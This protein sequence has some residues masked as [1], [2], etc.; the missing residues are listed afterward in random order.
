MALTAYKVVV[1]E[2][3]EKH[4]F[5]IDQY[6]QAMQKW[7]EEIADLDCDT[8]LIAIHVNDEQ[9][10]EQISQ[11][12]WREGPAFSCPTN[13]SWCQKYQIPRSRFLSAS[14][15]KYAEDA[16]RRYQEWSEGRYRY[17]EED[18]NGNGCT[19]ETGDEVGAM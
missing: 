1:P 5:D 6:P 4:F 17:P 13:C 14:A 9:A 8:Y 11:W 18:E 2:I 10:E 3:N 16:K 7:H 19:T 15:A 12:Y